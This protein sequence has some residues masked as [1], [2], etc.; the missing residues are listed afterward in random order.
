MDGQMA[1]DMSADWT[2]TAIGQTDED[3]ISNLKKKKP[4]YLRCL[5]RLQFPD[6]LALL[7]NTGERAGGGVC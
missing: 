3:M 5:L 1:W 2:R 7:G 4:R 6:Q